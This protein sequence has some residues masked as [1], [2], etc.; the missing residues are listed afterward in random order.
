[1]EK[2]KFEGYDQNSLLLKNEIPADNSL[3]FD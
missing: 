2:E 3:E 1:M